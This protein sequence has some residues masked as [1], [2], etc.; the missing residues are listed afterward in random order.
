MSRC[1]GEKNFGLIFQSFGKFFHQ[2]I[3]S[4]GWGYLIHDDDESFYVPSLV[5]EFYASFSCDNIDY[6]NDKI[7]ITWR[8]EPKVVDLDLIKE[9]TGIPRSQGA[10]NPL[11]LEE[12]LPIMG[13]VCKKPT[14]GG[15]KGTTMYRNVYAACKWII[16]NVAVTSQI[17]SFY[18]PTLHIAHSLMMHNYNFCMCKQLFHTICNAKVRLCTHPGMKLPLPCLITRICKFFISEHEFNLTEPDRIPVDTER[19]TRGYNHC[20][21]E[22]WIPV[23][24]Q[25]N[26]F[27]T[28]VNRMSETD[29]WNQPNPTKLEPFMEFTCEAL[30]RINTR[31][32]RLE[33]QSSSGGRTRKRRGGG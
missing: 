26:G 8:G 24:L 7:S 14:W 10:Q 15:I 1:L 20:Q 27:A 2:A 21:K 31:L 5:H 33:G 6:A 17:S 22:D 29:F 16:C 4:R 28:E 23:V 18:E 11:L 30:K 3:I 12:Y 25:E 13:D 19:V 9:L 32:E